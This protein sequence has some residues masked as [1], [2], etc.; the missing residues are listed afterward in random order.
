MQ[1]ILVTLF[2]VLFTGCLF[3]GINSKENLES[4]FRLSKHNLLWERAK[5]SLGKS[6]KL[7]TLYK[8]LKKLDKLSLTWKH[9]EN[10]DREDARQLAVDT[11]EMYLD[12]LNRYSLLSNRAASDGLQYTKPKFSQEVEKLWQEAVSSGITK[13]Y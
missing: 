12:I 6:P 13:S 9:L 3:H 1:E 4:P 11:K 8:E 10:K 5:E 7:D 2:L